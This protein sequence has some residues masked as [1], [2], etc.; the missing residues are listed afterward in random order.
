MYQFKTTSVKSTSVK[1]STFKLLTALM[2]LLSFSN[3]S[4]TEIKN[5]DVEINLDIPAEDREVGLKRM[6]LIDKLLSKDLIDRKRA[7]VKEIEADY[8]QKISKLLQGMISPI[9]KQIVITH[10]DVNFFAPDFDAKVHSNQAV[11]TSIM[12]KKNGFDVWSDQFKTKRE[13]LDAIKQVVSTTFGIPQ[14]KIS[15]MLN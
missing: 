5:S 9:N 10:I 8:N 3:L 1:S 12:I 6:E 11:S 15:I 2:L 13:A 14:E 4:A 7:L